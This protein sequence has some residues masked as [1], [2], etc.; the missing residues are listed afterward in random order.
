MRHTNAYDDASFGTF[1]KILFLILG[2]GFGIA[3]VPAE[4]SI[5]LAPVDQARVSVWANEMVVLTYTFNAENAEENLKKIAPY[6]TKEGWTAFVKAFSASQILETVKQ[7]KYR[8][9]SVAMAPPEILKQGVHNH[10]YVWTVFMPIL[11]QYKNESVS[12]KQCLEVTLTIVY[13][14]KK[15]GV[16]GLALEQF[17]AKKTDKACKCP[18]V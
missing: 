4:P 13:T 10:R 9:S 18:W 7:N 2:F 12:H 3:A 1:F 11:V 17:L 8:V 15:R 5:V 14:A 6:F 16:R